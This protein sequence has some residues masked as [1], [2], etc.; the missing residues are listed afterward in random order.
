M[1]ITQ[2]VFQDVAPQNYGKGKREQD[3]HQARGSWDFQI[4]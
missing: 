2:E 4:R 3:L 1:S